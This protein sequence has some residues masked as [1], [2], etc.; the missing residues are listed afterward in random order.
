ML[1]CFHGGAF[2]SLELPRV[3][4]AALFETLLSLG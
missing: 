2:L 1:G 4:E 3:I